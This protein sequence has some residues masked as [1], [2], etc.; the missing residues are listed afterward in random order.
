MLL[1]LKTYS[2]TR[3]NTGFQHHHE[4]YHHQ[5]LLKEGRRWI[6]QLYCVTNS[7]FG[8]LQLSLSNMSTAYIHSVIEYATPVWFPLMAKTHLDDIQCLQNRALQAAGNSG[9][10]MINMSTWSPPWSQYSTT[11][12][13]LRQLLPLSSQKTLLSLSW[14]PP[15]LTYSCIDHYTPCVRNMAAKFWCSI[16]TPGHCT[17]FCA[18]NM[19]HSSSFFLL[20][21]KPV[22]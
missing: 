16:T 22:N 14:G 4:K 15:L 13:S 8:P 19:W 12:Y 21:K 18:K 2:P 17:I 20:R 1:K 5:K 11:L 3:S 7:S 6:H 10:P 9:G